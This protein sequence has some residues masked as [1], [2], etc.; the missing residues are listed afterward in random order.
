MGNNMTLAYS[1]NLAVYTYRYGLQMSRFS[2][3]ASLG[4]FNSVV[5]LILL[6]SANRFSRRF[7]ED[8]VI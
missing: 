6:F 8:G 3:S 7:I 4:I 1:D 2:M 5:S